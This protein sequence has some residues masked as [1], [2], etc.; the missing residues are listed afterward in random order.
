M[1]PFLFRVNHRRIQLRNRIDNVARAGG[2]VVDLGI[3]A[4]GLRRVLEARPSRAASTVC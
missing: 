2:R 1:V 4:F 3:A